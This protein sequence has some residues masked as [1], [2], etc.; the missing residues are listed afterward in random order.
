MI[1]K[2]IYEAYKVMEIL[3][4]KLKDKNVLI[5]LDMKGIGSIIIN[6]ENKKYKK[7]FKENSFETDNYIENRY[8][9]AEEILK[10]L[11]CLL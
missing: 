3:K 8:R 9:L 11:E 4:D 1:L 10:D 6:Y 2:N 7:G 5:D